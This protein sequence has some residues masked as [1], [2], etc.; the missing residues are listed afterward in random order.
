[1]LARIHHYTLDRLRKEIEP[2]TAAQYVRWL[3]KW[4]HL[5]K[6]TR[7]HGEQ[8][9]LEIIRQ[10]QGF[11]IPA[12]AWE[13][14]V[15]A[16]RMTDYSA[17]YLDKLCLSGIIGWG[18]LS[19][20]PANDD[21][22]NKK[23]ITPSSIVPVTFFV[24]EESDWIP[25]APATDNIQQALSGLAKA[26]YQYLQQYGASFF[27][28]I[29]KGVGQLK[30]QVEDA[31]WELVAAGLITADGYDN[32]RALINV[33]RRL[34]KR[35]RL[36]NLRYSTGRW[37]LLRTHHVTDHQKYLEAVCWMLLKRYGVIFRDLV[38]REKHLPSWRELLM[39]LRRMEE[40]SEI[41][42]GRF[43]SGFL[44]EQFALSY[45]VDSLR[46]MRKETAVDESISISAADPLNLVG[47]ILPGS[48][49][50]A[51]SKQTIQL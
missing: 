3:L 19:P 25:P 21:A 2:V 42:G 50:A 51:N 15:F 49:V 13:K 46:L 37:S 23:R 12:N 44:G 24:R 34:D 35:R 27:S 5:A 48:K 41:R 28:D 20:H 11:E 40:R 45:A 14:E 4:Q 26:I 6:D 16:K 43:V 8:G 22:E 33:R 31:L 47:I 32:L 30:S 7:L 36:M 39:T 38:I 9:L 10:L 1:L 17:D 18:R 29:V